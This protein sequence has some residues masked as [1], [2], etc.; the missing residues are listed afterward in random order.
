MVRRDWHGMKTEN[1]KTK[2]ERTNMKKKLALLLAIVFIVALFAG[3]IVHGIRNR[4][5]RR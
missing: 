2:G 5:R 1:E 4:K 3:A